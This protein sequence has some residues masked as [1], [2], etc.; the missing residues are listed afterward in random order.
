MST[1]NVIRKMALAM[2]ARE[3][4]FESMSVYILFTPPLFPRPLTLVGSV[5]VNELA[6]E[7]QNDCHGGFRHCSGPILCPRR[8]EEPMK[9]D[10]EAFVFLEFRH[11]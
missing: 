2:Y 7:R 1:V 6:C 5:R 10:N 4:V 11:M 8:N 3:S 9:C